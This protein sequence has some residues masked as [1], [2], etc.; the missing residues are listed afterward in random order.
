MEQ[1]F[2]VV[3]VHFPHSPRAEAGGD[4]RCRY[5]VVVACHDAALDRHR[6]CG[7]SVPVR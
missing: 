7:G 4:W 1:R 3:T 5:V 6:Y 2:E